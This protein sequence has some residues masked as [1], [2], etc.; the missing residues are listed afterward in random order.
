MRC[1][2]YHSAPLRVSAGRDSFAACLQLKA[3]KSILNT[4]HPHHSFPRSLSNFSVAFSM[5]S[6]LASLNSRLHNRL[7]HR[8]SNLSL[9]ARGTRCAEFSPSCQSW[10]FFS[11]L[12]LHWQQDDTLRHLAAAMAAYRISLAAR[13]I[14][15]L[16]Q[17]VPPCTGNQLEL[18]SLSHYFL[19]ERR[20]NFIF[21]Q[22]EGSIVAVAR[23]RNLSALFVCH[24]GGIAMSPALRSRRI[25]AARCRSHG[26]A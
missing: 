1:G 7:P 3:L 24:C 26:C 23:T 5:Q 17:S 9:W 14:R 21:M 12:P 10:V 11:F 2:T 8:D 15:V 4:Q 13:Q 20:R 22:S 25:P 16:S 18:P 6:R 19:F